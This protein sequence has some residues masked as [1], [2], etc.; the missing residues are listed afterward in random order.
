GNGG[1]DE[2]ARHLES[3]EKQDD[4]EKVE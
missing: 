1:S 2:N 4:G 3:D